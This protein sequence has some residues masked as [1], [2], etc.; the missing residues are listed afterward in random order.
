MELAPPTSVIWFDFE[1]FPTTEPPIA[2]GTGESAV[3]YRKLNSTLAPFYV[4]FLKA[5]S[6][7]EIANITSTYL[8]FFAL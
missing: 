6:Q 1:L 3:L 7:V 5:T 8:I 2:V 4:L